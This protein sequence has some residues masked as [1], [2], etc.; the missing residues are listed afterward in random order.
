MVNEVSDSILEPLGGLSRIVVP[1]HQT[2]SPEPDVS[3]LKD[4]LLE[5]VIQKTGREL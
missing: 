4:D 1:G 3:I 5:V 2:T